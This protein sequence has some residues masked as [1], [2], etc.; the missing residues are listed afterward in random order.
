MI[1]QVGVI[2][3]RL[4]AIDEYNRS[5]DKLVDTKLDVINKDIDELKQ[6]VR[7]TRD[8]MKRH[9]GAIGLVAFLVPVLLVGME[10]YTGLREVEQ[11]STTAALHTYS[12][13]QWL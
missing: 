7:E 8:G 5:Q 13:T 3:G 12:V 4:A 6:D 11:Q 1:K 10:V 9:A 2:S